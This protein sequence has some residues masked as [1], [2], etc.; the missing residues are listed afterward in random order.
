MSIKI[1]DIP[2]NDRPR[3]RLINIGVNN[4]SNEEVLAII[5]GSGT[6]NISAKELANNILREIKDLSYLNDITLN[7]LTKIKGIGIKKACS[8][9]S[10]IELGKRISTNVNSINSVKFNNPKVIYEYYKNKL[11]SKKQEYFYCVYLDSSKKIILEKLLFIGTINQSIVHPR[12]VF[13]EAYLCDATSIVCLHNHPS[14]N[15]LPSREDIEIT[16][17]LI[18]IGSLFGIVITDHIII[19][20][21][22]YYSL[23]EN[24]DM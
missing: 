22:K 21:N 7:E 17:K 14:G 8:I 3:E 19:T 4:L 13:K 2:I 23:Y 5:L 9:I 10:S 20:K 24:G 16:N 15:V 12:E 18:E 6:K 1:K 11:G